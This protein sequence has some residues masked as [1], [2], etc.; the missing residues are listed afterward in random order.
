MNML[1]NLNFDKLVDSR[2]MSYIKK[3]NDKLPKKVNLKIIDNLDIKSSTLFDEEE[4]KELN[5]KFIK[6]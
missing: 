1:D 2:D 4:Q 5:N 3:T 6:D